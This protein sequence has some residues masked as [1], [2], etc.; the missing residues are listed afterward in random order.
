M[1]HPMLLPIS[2]MSRIHHPSL[3]KLILIMVTKRYGHPEHISKYK[4]MSI[5]HFVNMKRHINLWHI[6]NL[7][8]YF[9]N[10]II[11]ILI[12]IMITASSNTFIH[13]KGSY[14][15]HCDVCNLLFWPPVIMF[16]N[17]FFFLFPTSPSSLS[18][19]SITF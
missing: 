5:K 10:I 13:R 7:K 19:L 12:I 18:R 16:I 17:I 15:Q 4:K 8:W 6:L 3:P 11:I 9:I 2:N 1:Y 14:Q